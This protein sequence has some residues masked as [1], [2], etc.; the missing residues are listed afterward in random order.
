MCGHATLASAYVLF[1]C[2]GYS[3]E[4][5]RFATRSGELIVQRSGDRL[6]M[7]FPL[8][9]PTVCAAPAALLAGLKATPLAVLAADDYMAVFADAEQVRDLQPDLAEL[10]KLDLR[11]VIV[12]APGNEV[13][14]V[15]RFFGPKVGIPED[16]V[17]GSA[18]CSLAPYWGER[19]QKN[20]LR[21]R[22]I[23]LRGGDL[24]CELKGD[25]VLLYGQAVKFMEGE[26]HLP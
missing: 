3:G 12:T 22:Q 26:I 25:R 1:E 20:A 15:S 17:T 21:A 11:G 9:T 16:P 2:L 8:R 13:D 5:I 19:L 18:H 6:K 4:Q 23:S 7:D 24:Q 14:F 10:A